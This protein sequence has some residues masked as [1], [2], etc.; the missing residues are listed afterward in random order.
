MGKRKR[1][2][3]RGREL[4]DS[5]ASAGRSALKEAQ[6]H[7]PPDLWQQIEKRLRIIQVQMARTASQADLT[8]LSRRIDELA[9]RL[10]QIAKE[11]TTG[12][13][14]PRRAASGA[15]APSRPRQRTPAAGAKTT[16][17]PRSS[18]GSARPAPR[19][20][21]TRKP[22]PAPPTPPPAS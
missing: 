3:S 12:A 10:D 14:R 1:A 6:R 15:A 20:T 21:R 9:R 22:P 13:P 11:G 19:R 7:V 5:V 16:G 8:R 2:S 18:T 17:S 4:F